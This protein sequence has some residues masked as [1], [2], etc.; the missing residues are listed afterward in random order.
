MAN[1]GPPAIWKNSDGLIVRNGP[2]EAVPGNVGSY[3]DHYGGG[4]IIE[5]FVDFG[6]DVVSNGLVV[7]T[8]ATGVIGALL[9]ANGA[10]FIPKTAT[11]EKMEIFV[12]KALVG[13]TTLNMGL[14]NSDFTRATGAG[15]DVGLLN[16]ET[17]SNLGTIGRRWIYSV[18]GGALDGAPGT[19]STHQGTGLGLPP[20]G[21]SAP[22]DA[23]PSIYTTGT[24]TSGRLQIRIFLNYS[25]RDA[26]LT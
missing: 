14:L 9:D 12:T 25:A 24:F 19:T 18:S 7:G 20:G 22:V 2:T 10:F 4:E 15:D 11:I 26:I 17:Q 13:G 8:V 5:A 3:E 16:A 23:Y 21:T 6:T 1:S